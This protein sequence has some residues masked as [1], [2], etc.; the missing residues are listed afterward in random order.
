MASSRRTSTDL[1]LIA[2]FGALVAASA[3][4]PAIPVGQLGV[5]ITLQTFAVLLAGAVLGSVRGFLA[6]ALYVVVGL[7]GAPIFA[8]GNGGLGVLAGPSAGYL[9]AFAPAAFLCGFLVERLPRHLLARSVPL[10]S[11]AGLAGLVVNHLGGLLGL[12]LRFDLT[13]TEAVVADLPY[14]PGDL[15]KVVAVA[16]VATAVHR[17]FPDLLG[18]P[19]TAGERTPSVTT[20]A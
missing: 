19:A 8:G 17:A 14:V 7:A 20:P 11:L 15:V 4:L 2:G 9:L 6:V 5:P 1:A 13:W 12:V 18:R 10:I 16:L 3:I